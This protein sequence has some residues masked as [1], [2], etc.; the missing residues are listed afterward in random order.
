MKK[1]PNL[2]IGLLFFGALAL[3]VMQGRYVDHLR[4]SDIFY[5][6]IISSANQVRVFDRL[7]D[8]TSYLDIVRAAADIAEV[9]LFDRYEIMRYWNVAGTFDL[10][11]LKDDGLYEKIHTCIG[12]LLAD[13]ILRGAG[14][15]ESK[16]IGG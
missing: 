7:V 6:W 2:L 1:L 12:E 10:T 4:E 9:P 15:K 8:Y 14:M 16:G 5:R 3:A 11:S 13:F